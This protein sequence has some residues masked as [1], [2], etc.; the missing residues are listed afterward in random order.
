M[1]PKIPFIV[2]TLILAAGSALWAQT[3]LEPV[4][5]RI[6][7]GTG[8]DYSR[9]D[10]GFAADTEVFSVP[11]NL[12]RESEH[13]L[14]RATVPWL[15]IRGPATVIG[16]G[17]GGA[18][19]PDASEQSGLGDTY[20]SATYRMGHVFAGWSADLSGRVKLPTADEARGLGTGEADYYAQADLRR[21]F[22]AVTPFG[23]VGYRVLGDSVRYQ[24]RDGLYASGGAF[25][26]ASDATVVGVSL[27]WRERLEPAADHATEVTGFVTHDLSPRWQMIAYGLKG[28]TRGSPDIG[29]G[30][31]LNYRF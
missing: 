14:L 13:W 23:S 28:F 20:L 2:V 15:T 9:G 16:G 29:A 22:G 26:R 25:Y 27:D 17:N 12:S 19:R 31:H 6:S 30:A 4:P 3:T 10:Y 21:T 5:A 11:F 24:L 18:G 1:H 7:V 8:F